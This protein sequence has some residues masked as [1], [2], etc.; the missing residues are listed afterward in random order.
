MT[1]GLGHQEGKKAENLRRQ[2][3]IRIDNIKKYIYYISS[4]SGAF[5]TRLPQYMYVL[6]NNEKRI[7]KQKN[8]KRMYVAPAFVHRHRLSQLSPV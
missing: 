8:V 1:N 4:D 5:A 3:Y 6:L 2:Y 7:K